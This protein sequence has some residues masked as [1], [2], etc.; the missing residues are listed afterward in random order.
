MSVQQEI[1]E[2]LQKRFNPSFLKVTNDSHK[3]RGHAGDNGT[4]SSHFSALV[5]SDEFEG[6]NLVKR[7]Q[8]VYKALGDYMKDIIHAL[9]LKT[10]TDLEYNKIKNA[11]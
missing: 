2:I 9:A 4:G 5:V 8:E 11:L 3:H 1:E 10:M 7:Q 6:L